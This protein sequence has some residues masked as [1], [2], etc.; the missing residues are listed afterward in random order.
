M[1]SYATAS[2][3]EQWFAGIQFN[4]K[5][6]IN[7]YNQLISL[8]RTGLSKPEALHMAWSV[9]SNE[10]RDPKD[11]DAVILGD[12]IQKMHNG[13]TIGQALRKW[14]P[15]DDLMVLE[16]IENSDDFASNL[17]EYIEMLEKKE[18]IRNTILSGLAYPSLLLAAIYGVLIYFGNSI[19]PQ[20]ATVLPMDQWSGPARILALMA[21]FSQQYAMTTTIAFL[22]ALGI[23][24]MLLPIWAGAGRSHAD[25]LPIFAIYRMY[26]G[27]SFLMSMSSLI[28]G[29]MTQLEAIERLRPNAN[30]YVRYRLTKV[31]DHML[32]GFN[33]GAA[34]HQ[35]GTNWPDKK[36]N[37]QIKVYAETHDLSGQLATLAKTWVN[38]AQ[39]RMEKV[40]ATFKTFAMITVFLGVFT[41]I[42]GIYNLQDQIG[43]ASAMGAF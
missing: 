7:L 40:M 13:L 16:A 18:K 30:R 8:T 29:G 2:G 17:E 1:A 20:I 42:G 22:C 10:G 5:K 38:Q 36:M 23:I 15:R 19:L 14:V 9:A 37:L 3:F 27:L 35:S 34:L 11:F 43:Q 21:T 31:R 6:R 41:I 25:R 4:K 28:Q 26:T 33:F 32:N 12:V 39:S 24:F